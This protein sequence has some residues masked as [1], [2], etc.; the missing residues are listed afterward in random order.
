MASRIGKWKYD[1]ISIFCIVL[2]VSVYFFHYFYPEPKLIIT[3]DYGAS[4]SWHRSISIKYVMWEALQENRIP[5]WTSLIGTG[6]PLY[7]DAIG[8]FYLPNL[9]LFRFFNFAIAYNLFI[10]FSLSLFGIGLYIWLRSMKIGIP[11]ALMAGLALSISG[12]TIPRLEHIMVIPGLSLIP[13]IFWATKRLSDK[14]EYKNVLLFI[15]LLWQQILTT[16]PQAVFI[17]L[18]FSALY[19]LL[20]KP[21]IIYF[22]CIASAFLLSAFQLLPSQEYYGQSIV[23]SGF[24]SGTAG[25]YAYTLSNFIT[26]INPF[27]FGNPVNGTYSQELAGNGVFFWENASFFGWIP[28]ILL[29]VELWSLK[30]RKFSRSDIFLLLSLGLSFLL[31]LGNNSPTYLMYSIWPF[32]VFRSPSRF[33][34]IFTLILLVLSARGFDSVWKKTKSPLLWILLIINTI[35]VFYTWNGY[36]VLYN[37]KEWLEKPDIFKYLNS[38][39]RIMTFAVEKQ[40]EDIRQNQGDRLINHLYFTRN[41]LFPNTNAVYDVAHYSEQSGIYNRRALYFDQSLTGSITHDEQS[42]ISTASA[43]T[44]KLAALQSIGSLISPYSFDALEL[45]GLISHDSYNLYVYGLPGTLPRSYIAYDVRTATT[46]QSAMNIMQSDS[47]IPGFSVLLEHTPPPVA[48]SSA[49]PEITLTESGDNTKISVQIKDNPADG[50]L[51]L[52]DKYYPGWTVSVN[53]KKSEIYAANMKQRAVFVPGGTHT[54]QFTYKAEMF[55]TGMLISAV[56]ACIIILAG[57][58]IWLFRVR[59]A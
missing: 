31:M 2:Y 4:D 44:R 22:I 49:Q 48:S 12:I 46:V 51:V 18:I 38:G 8:F 53:G 52:T 6:H 56:T 3:P 37:A 27:Y 42:Q 59:T 26:F 40:Y 16:F 7:A 17:T 19:A 5:F 47:F 43:T 28:L 41:T 54:V 25:R 36:H 14:S 1:L 29:L 35:H 23:N 57:F 24:D 39:E 33:L 15:F 10:V 50:M 58:R 20:I 11:A 13:W 9:I 21:R 45:K 34:W 30:N 55:K 32:N